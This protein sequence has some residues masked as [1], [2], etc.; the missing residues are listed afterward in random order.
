MTVGAGGQYVNV[1]MSNPPGGYFSFCRRVIS[2]I[3]A[4]SCAQRH[5]FFCSFAQFGTGVQ[6]AKSMN[7]GSSGMADVISTPFLYETADIFRGIP[8][9]AKCFTLLRHPV[10]RAV[11][12]Y[13]LYQM[14]DNG[15]PST[16]QYRGM[17]IDQYAESA[18]ENNWMVRFL[19]SKRAGTLTW[20]DLEAAK[21]GG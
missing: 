1:N 7:L 12:L 21:E 15:N 2:T 8:E 6:R 11:A 18:A 17:T 3:Y 14:D 19:T 4:H 10:D 13:H 16:A 5:L 9:S 20:H